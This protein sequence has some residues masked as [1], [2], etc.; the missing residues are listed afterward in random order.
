MEP[1]LRKQFSWK[2]VLYFFF[3]KG[4]DYLHF[5]SERKQ[6]NCR[7]NVKVNPAIK[8]PMWEFLSCVL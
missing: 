2:P 5:K 3:R 7:I 4:I 1:A 6:T 8:E